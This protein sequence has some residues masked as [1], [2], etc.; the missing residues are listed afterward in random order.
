MWGNWANPVP[1]KMSD[2]KGLAL[3]VIKMP[4]R[5]KPR[6]QISF[7]LNPENHSG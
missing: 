6:L 3:W 4:S 2:R 1:R 7:P 5:I